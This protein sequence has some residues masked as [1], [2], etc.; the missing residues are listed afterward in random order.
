MQFGKIA[1][2]SVSPARLTSLQVEVNRFVL[3]IATLAF[4]TGAI[5]VCV[6]VARPR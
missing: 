2:Q 3:I 6:R 1:A 4:V 5:V